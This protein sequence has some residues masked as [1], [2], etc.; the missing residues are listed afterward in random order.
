[1]QSAGRDPAL[2]LDVS[3]GCVV[4][5]GP[6][7]AE[8]VA[9]LAVLAH[10][11][12]RQPEPPPRLQV[13]REPEDR[14]RQQ[15]HLVVNDQTPV[16]GVEERQVREGAAAAGRDDL[17][18]RDRHRADLLTLARILADLLLG[19]RCPREQFALPLA[20]RDRIRHQDQGRGLGLGHRGR[21]HERLAGAAG[22]HDHPGSAGPEVLHRLFLVRP[23]VPVHLV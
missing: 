10:E 20:T 3:P 5:L 18:G 2:R 12:G 1:V 19:E 14:R 13:G 7:Q 15:M 11:R 6:D 16:A 4:A 9:L 22:E 8:D 21:A 17:I 23:Q